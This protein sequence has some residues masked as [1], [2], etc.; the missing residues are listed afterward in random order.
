[1]LLGELKITTWCSPD[2]KTQ[3]WRQDD[4]LLLGQILSSIEPC[5]QNLVLH[6]RTVKKIWIYSVFR[7]Q[8]PKLSLWCHSGA[9]R[10]VECWPCSM[11]SSTNFLRS[12]RFFLSQL[13]W[14]RCRSGTLRPEL[15]KSRSNVMGSSTIKSLENTYF[16]YEIVPSKSQNLAIME[17]QDRFAFGV[18][19]RT[20]GGRGRS[21][22]WRQRPWVILEVVVQEDEHERW[23][24]VIIVRSQATPNTIAHY[25]TTR[26]AAA[27]L[28]A[29]VAIAQE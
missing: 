26:E 17:T 18:Q 4:A 27:V 14:R 7:R 6:C 15:L 20:T 3:T 16:L 19:G 5:V 11:P 2:P 22:F 21:W 29:H 1:M 8:Q 28:S 24:I 25:T 9:N 12:R 10:K 13:M 23:S